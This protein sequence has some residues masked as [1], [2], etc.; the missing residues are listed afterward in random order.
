MPKWRELFVWII[1]L[2]LVVSATT[3]AHYY[4]MSDDSVFTLRLVSQK[5]GDLI[6][7]QTAYLLIIIA[8]LF[9]ARRSNRIS[10]IEGYIAFAAMLTALLTLL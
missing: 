7:G 10:E 5:L 3:I 6:T 2:V 9:G 8:L 1:E 4:I